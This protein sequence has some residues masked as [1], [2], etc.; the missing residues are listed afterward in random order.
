[1]L[2]FQNAY[3]RFCIPGL[4]MI[5]A[6]VAHLAYIAGPDIPDLWWKSWL[7][8][9]GWVLILIGVTLWLGSDIGFRNRQ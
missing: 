4:G 1:M 6:S 3:A 2:A 7:A 5:M 9:L 8:V